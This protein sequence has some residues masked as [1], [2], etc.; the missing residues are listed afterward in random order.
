MAKPSTNSDDATALHR[1]LVDNLLSAGSVQTPRVEEAFR[2]V[3]RHLFLPGV[4]LDQVYSDV[5]IPTKHLEDQVVSSS[6]QPAMMA[7]MLEQLRLEPGHRVLEIGS[8]T[9]YNAALM[10]HL[11]GDTGRVVTVEL[12]ED[13]AATARENLS[14]AGFGRVQVICDDGAFGVPGEAP[15]DR[16]ILTVGARDIAPAWREQLKPGGRLLLP[17]SLA[18]GGQLSVAWEHAGGHLA[19][20]SVKPCGFMMLRGT[21]AAPDRA[22]QLG[23]EPDLQ[24]YVDDKSLVDSE[25]VYSS[26]TGLAQDFRTNVRVTQL[27]IYSGLVLWLALHG[28]GFCSLVATG[29]WAER[30][31]V[32]DLFRMSSEGGACSTIGLH[33]NGSLCVLMP[34][35]DQTSPADVS[36]DSTPFELFVRRFGPDDSLV[37]Q[38]TNQIIDW[39]ISGRPNLENIRLRAYPLDSDYA[40]TS[41]ESVITNRW[42]RLVVDWQ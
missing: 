26:L 32:P 22:I 35:L 33:S 21:F 34:H 5:S 41:R 40:A 4:S 39:D 31:I 7:I 25:A 24:I 18:G 20:V 14:Q 15:Y 28:V 6:S 29:D 17:L 30:N 36:F 2:K 10:A 42:T 38:L 1:S 19:S 37:Q 27:E 11:A 23:P 8:G 9:G 12:D 13:L 16:I 3:P